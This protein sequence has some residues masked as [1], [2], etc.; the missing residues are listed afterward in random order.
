METKTRIGR[1]IVVPTLLPTAK[2]YSTITG[3]RLIWSKRPRS[4][5]WS[6]IT[7]EIVVVSGINDFLAPN[8]IIGHLSE[9]VRGLM[10]CTTTVRG[11]VGCTATVE[12][13]G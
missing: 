12:A 1:E 8:K 3:G 10:G 9:Y 5:G 6:S 2:T 11:L 4:T 7:E 13:F